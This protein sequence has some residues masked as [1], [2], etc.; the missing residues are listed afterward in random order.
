MNYETMNVRTKDVFFLVGGSFCENSFVRSFVRLLG[1]LVR[2]YVGWYVG[3]I[4]SM[5][6]LLLGL[7]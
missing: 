4:H 2:W 1:M 5:F 3:T 6:R 7:N